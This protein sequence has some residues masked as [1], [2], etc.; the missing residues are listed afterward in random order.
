[1]ESVVAALECLGRFVDENSGSLYYFGPALRAVD[2][3]DDDALAEHARLDTIGQQPKT[4]R[5]SL[6]PSNS[7]SALSLSLSPARRRRSRSQAKGIPSGH[8][9]GLSRVDTDPVAIDQHRLSSSPTVSALLDAPLSSLRRSQDAEVGMR[10]GSYA[11]NTSPRAPN[12]S[13]ALLLTRMSSA[14]AAC[15]LSALLQPSFLPHLYPATLRTD[16]C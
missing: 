2:D 1:M 11:G 6:V 5:D 15:L 3:V 7:F 4:P 14:Q 10:Q 8:L 13:E 16:H 9:G 12:T